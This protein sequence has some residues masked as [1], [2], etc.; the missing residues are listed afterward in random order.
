MPTAGWSGLWNRVGNEQH[1]LL[2]PRGHVTA[3]RIAKIARSGIGNILST[4][5]VFTNLNE[6]VKQ[7][8]PNAQ[9]GNPITNGG[10]IPI[11]VNNLTPVPSAQFISYVE[12]S[13][14]PLSYPPD[15]SGNG[16]GGKLGTHI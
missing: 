14:V 10:M 7:V 9:P 2:I 4:E 13:N 6:D 1:A 3:R 12:K 15:R 11:A 16:G 5:R 8:T